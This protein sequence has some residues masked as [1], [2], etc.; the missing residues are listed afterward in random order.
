M[1]QTISAAFARGLKCPDMGMPSAFLKLFVF[2]LL[3]RPLNR[4]AV[5]K[6]N[7]KWVVICPFSH[8]LPLSNLHRYVTYKIGY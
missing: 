8:A 3:N 1:S 5:E 2:R 4:Y 7:L 6:C